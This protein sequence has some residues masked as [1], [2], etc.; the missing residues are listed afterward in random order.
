MR[1]MKSSKKI[2]CRLLILVVIDIIIITP[3]FFPFRNPL[4]G[5]TTFFFI[6]LFCTVMLMTSA[7]FIIAK[8]ADWG[9][10]LLMNVIAFWMIALL[11]SYLHTYI[12]MDFGH[13]I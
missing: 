10:A 6:C 3:Y 8:K 13:I 4:D 5:L 1:G 2:L 9:Y 7:I 12:F 11:E